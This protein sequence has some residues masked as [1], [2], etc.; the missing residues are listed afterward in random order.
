MC[1]TV[2]IIICR[3]RYEF[4]SREHEPLELGVANNSNK[5]NPFRLTDCTDYTD[6]SFV[7]WDFLL[8][9]MGHCPGFG[10]LFLS[11]WSFV[12]GLGFCSFQNGALSRTWNFVPFKKE[13]CPELLLLLLFER[14]ISKSWRSTKIA[15]NLSFGA[16][17]RKKVSGFIILCVIFA[18]RDI[19][20]GLFYVTLCPYSEREQ[21]LCVFPLNKP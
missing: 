2:Y 6:F 3:Q 20:I 9:K 14:S 10:I 19:E 7:S 18:F 12:P 15:R 4:F 21:A 8:F 5:T 11:K 13:H 16:A 1:Y 17:T